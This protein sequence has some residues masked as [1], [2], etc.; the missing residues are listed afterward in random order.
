VRKWIALGSSV[1]LLTTLTSGRAFAAD[2]KELFNKVCAGCHGETGN[3]DTK[4]GKAAKAKS[5][6]E[7]ELNSKLTAADAE[8]FVT[9]NVRTSKKHKNVTKK[10]TDEELAAIAAYVKVLAAKP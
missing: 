2:G 4:K 8:A 10:V 6:H 7:A 5:Y 3:A 9:K 1:L